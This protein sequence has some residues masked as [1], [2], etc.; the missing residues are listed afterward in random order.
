MS[1]TLRD[2]LQ[3]V[4]GDGY[5]VERELARGGMSR[6]FLATER[7]LNRQV[8]VKLLPPELASELSA[9]RFQR[10][11]L[12]TAKLQHPHILPVL[13][14]GARGTFLYYVMPY[15]RGESLRV[16][17]EREG[18][19]PI[20]EAI[21][22]LRELAEALAAAHAEG[23]VH[24]DVK[25]ENVLL[26]HG[27]AL[28][29]DF[30]IAHARQ[31]AVEGE[32][33][34]GTGL[35]LG[36]PGYMAPEQLAGSSDVDG[37]ADIY[38]LGVLGYEMLAGAPPFAGGTPQELV[39]AHFNR[40]PPLLSEVRPDVPRS[41]SDAI[42][43]AL[44]KSPE[45]RFSTATAFAEAL[46]SQ[47]AANVSA[48]RPLGA[49]AVAPRASA[50]NLGW[51]VSRTCN[52][53]SQ[54]NAFDAHFG[55]EHRSH[56]WRPQVYV[57]HGDEGE[58]H[59]SLVERLVA[60]RISR[61]AAEW[62]GLDRGSVAT[63]K[64]PWPVGDP[65]ETRKR[66]LQ[67]ALFREADPSYFNEELSAR[68]LGR[69][70]PLVLNAAVVIQHR[71]SAATWDKST[72]A[73]LAW[74][75]D[76]YWGELTESRNGPLFIVFLEL[77]YP[78]ARS[79][80]L[81]WPP[82]SRAVATTRILQRLEQLLISQPRR[83]ST[84]IFKV[85]SS[86]TA[87][88]VKQWFS[89]NGIYDSE[90]R[91]RE[92][93]DEIFAT[94]EIKKMAEVE[95]VLRE[96]HRVFVAELAAPAPRTDKR[97][98]IVEAHRGL[99]PLSNPIDTARIPSAPATIFVSYASED[100][101]AVRRLVTALRERGLDARFDRDADSARLGAGTAYDAEILRQIQS[102]AVFMP[103]ISRTATTRLVNANFRKEWT[104]AIERLS[105]MHRELPFMVP[106]IIDD[107]PE[108]HPKIEEPIW[109]YQVARLR[110][111]VPTEEFIKELES[112]VRTMQDALGQ[113]SVT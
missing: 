39:A 88:D 76:E 20:A 65:L 50:R 102:C 73:L 7:A 29:A 95:A 23:V 41:V 51:I 61:V 60:T 24:R 79:M 53:W 18:R 111:G 91:W 107:T 34:T 109:R 40:I 90:Q 33:L 38:A 6:L 71:L 72:E 112:A 22:L 13:S 54:V 113:V 99:T 48:I 2:E 69:L 12:L 93:S 81:R 36:T 103:I 47:S 80:R 21:R 77:V 97:H 14:A 3:V 58:A 105:M 63:I 45:R 89:Q 57:V 8:V 56:P 19:L 68:A 46:E 84:M 42:A 59:E 28:L 30:G 10:E 92:L 31:E 94:S 16:R 26:E 44:A 83:C 108:G 27:H 52:R 62:G 64:V 78:V 37:R 70:A 87:D 43:R 25:P 55:A 98:S 66:D 67:I 85:L 32:R 35:G 15:V 49:S 1:P 106:V 4:L 101:D 104:C 96:I 100:R 5:F 9:Q 17:F 86:V 74:Y 75:V 82:W 11:M 110:N